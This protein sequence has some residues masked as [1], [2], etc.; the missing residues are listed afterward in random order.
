MCPYCNKASFYSPR[1]L[2]RHI[3]IHTG[4]KP[5]RC[6]HCSYR[7]RLKA[8]MKSHLLRIHGFAESAKV[9]GH[10]VSQVAQ[11]TQHSQDTSL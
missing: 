5:Y 8:H 2:E 11:V 6:Q 9:G 4:E 3:R 10:G 7:A 1:D